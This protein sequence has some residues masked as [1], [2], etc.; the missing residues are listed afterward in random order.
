MN[1]MQMAEFL[2]LNDS[3]NKGEVTPEKHGLHG[4][5]KIS[6]KNNDTGKVSLWEESDNIIPISGYN[7]LLLKIFGL[8]LDSIHDPSNKGYE[9]LDK[10]TTVAVPDLNEINSMA[11]GCDPNAY[12]IMN[13]SISADHFIQGFMVGTGGAGEDANTT[14]N[15]DYSFVSLRNPIPFQETNLP[16][17]PPAIANKYLGAVRNTDTTGQTRPSSGYYI[18]KFDEEPHV[19]HSWYR[20]GQKWDYLD[21]ITKNDLG[22]MSANIAKT[23]RIETYAQCHLSIEGNDCLAAFNHQ[24]SPSTTPKINE[25]GLVS[26]NT[27]HGARS[28]LEALEKSIVQPMLR[29]VFD[30]N[31]ITGQTL[32]I[33]TKV[34]EYANALKNAFDNVDTDKDGNIIKITDFNNTRM[35]NFYRTISQIAELTPNSI[36]YARYISEFSRTENIHVIGYYNQN[37]ELQYT[38]DEY[39]DILGDTSFDTLT[40][41]EAERIKLFTYY[42]FTGIPLEENISILI[43]YRIY[44]N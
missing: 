13:E 41:D 28:K 24:T 15:T 9:K 18:K 32:G 42:T 5:V 39:V 31:N 34:I 44:A 7:W 23:N 4:H 2:S 14:K 37:N 26:F 16:N 30:K 19:Y 38:T 27:I 25:L 12:S 35:N 22:P 21:P 6:I 3:I 11:I 8:Q 29:I 43:D 10:D 40:T 33:N 20:D 17:L 36:D 1:N